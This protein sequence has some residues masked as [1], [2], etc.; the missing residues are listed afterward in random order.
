MAERGTQATRP[1]ARVTAR[2]GLGEG[3]YEQLRDAIVSGELASGMPL[4]EVALAERF[5]TS[6]TPVRE[7]LARLAIE[8]LVRTEPGRGARVADVSLTD[9]GELFQMR[10]LLESYVARLAAVNRE[11]TVELERLIEAFK[12]YRDPSAN[13]PTEAYYELTAELDEALIDRVHNS[14]LKA[15]LRDVW[16]HSHRLR[17]YASHDP[18]RLATSAVEHIAILTAVCA[19]NADAAEQ[20]VRSHLANGRTSI[21]SRLLANTLRGS[22][23]T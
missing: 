8:G 21:V 17:Q 18:E 10:E 14:R 11:Q 12:P 23:E 20:A 13:L 15:A 3:A 6:R 19:G 16:L 5:A 2:R 1:K 7:A 4:S 9:I 22:D